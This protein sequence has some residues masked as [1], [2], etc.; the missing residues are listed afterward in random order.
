MNFWVAVWENCTAGCGVGIG[1]TVVG[2]CVEAVPGSGVTV[3]GV[4]GVVGVGVCWFRLARAFWARRA[5]AGN[6]ASAATGR[7]NNRRV[8]AP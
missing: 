8:R 5:Q 6:R 7:A 4:V 2:V 1:V 3:V